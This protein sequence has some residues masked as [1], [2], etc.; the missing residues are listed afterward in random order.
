MD[1]SRPARVE[2]MNSE[3]LLAIICPARWCGRIG[4][5][6]QMGSADRVPKS[7]GTSKA[8]DG[9]GPVRSSGQPIAI[10]SFSCKVRCCPDLGLSVLSF[11]RRGTT[12]QTKTVPNSSADRCH[13]TPGVPFQTFATIGLVTRLTIK[14]GASPLKAGT[15]SSGGVS[16]HAFFYALFCWPLASANHFVGCF[17]NACRRDDLWANFLLFQQPFRYHHPIP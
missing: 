11:P 8:M 12:V 6:A 17:N 9:R 10:S 5:L 13:V 16:V 4:P 2:A 3:R 14:G 1:G 15:R 7:F